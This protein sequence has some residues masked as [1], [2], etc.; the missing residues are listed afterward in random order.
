MNDLPIEKQSS[1]KKSRSLQEL[2]RTQIL[3]RHSG[4]SFYACSETIIDLK[5]MRSI[6]P[7][8]FILSLERSMTTDRKCAGSEDKLARY[9]V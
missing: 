4:Y 1:F 9:K 2:R 5:R 6:K 8:S 3:I 7:E